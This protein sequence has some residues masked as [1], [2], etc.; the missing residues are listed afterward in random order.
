M[1]KRSARALLYLAAASTR[2]HA[3]VVLLLSQNETTAEPNGASRSQQPAPS[4]RGDCIHVQQ[5]LQGARTRAAARSCSRRRTRTRARA[6][7]TP[8]GGGKFV[9]LSPAS[10]IHRGG[11]GI[12]EAGREGGRARP[13]RLLCC[14]CVCQRAGVLP[15]SLLHGRRA[16]G[17][18][19]TSRARG[20]DKHRRHR[21]RRRSR[22]AALS[23]PSR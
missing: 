6:L 7:C 16:C 12:G 2:A 18:L 22:G 17:L 3:R 4:A 23:R 10:P 13:D 20:K 1:Q 8:L 15:L 19:L 5:E 14:V 9:L 21:R 11:R